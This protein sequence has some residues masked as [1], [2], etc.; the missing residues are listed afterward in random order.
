MLE[1]RLLVKLTEA[2]TLWDTPPY[3]TNDA[4]E[5]I[6]GAISMAVD[7]D[8]ENRI[9]E[10]MTEGLIPY[11]H[12]KSRFLSGHLR[13][14]EA[15]LINSESEWYWP[16]HD[17]CEQSDKAYSH[18][19]STGLATITEW[20][21]STIG[22]KVHRRNL[23]I[24]DLKR[25]IQVTENSLK[26]LMSTPPQVAFTATEAKFMADTISDTMAVGNKDVGAQERILGK[27][28]KIIKSP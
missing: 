13:A 12:L 2:K 5:V 17:M 14:T 18:H 24:A 9:S 22:D 28:A 7:T 6:N 3:F 21:C 23:Q 16:F 27:L 20:L 4:Q 15:D 25:S 8:W 10:L 1:A 19:V 26:R 11:D